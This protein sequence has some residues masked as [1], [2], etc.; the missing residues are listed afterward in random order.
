[1]VYSLIDLRCCQLYNTSDDPH[2]NIWLLPSVLVLRYASAPLLFCHTLLTE[3]ALGVSHARVDINV[4]YLD[5]QWAVSRTNEEAIALPAQVEEDE[6]RTGEVEL[7]E[8]FSTQVR[9]A[10]RVKCNVELT[11]E[12]ENVDKQA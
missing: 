7:E 4:L 11:H 9:T 3:Y 1:M 8:N 12:S 2:K 10:D 6:Q 5:P